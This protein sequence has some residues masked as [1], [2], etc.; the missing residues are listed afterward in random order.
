MYQDLIAQITDQ[1]IKNYVLM[2]PQNVMFVP[3]P[4]DKSFLSIQRSK[5]ELDIFPTLNDLLSFNENKK[6]TIFTVP[7]KPNITL[8]V[9][10][11]F[12]NIKK[13][14]VIYDIYIKIQ[15]GWLIVSSVKSIMFK[16]T[17]KIN[18]NEKSGN[19]KTYSRL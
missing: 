17:V 13:Q 4:S 18:Q 1:Q 7:I 8:I 15:T 9:S 3:V 14:R 16:N 12:C 5:S 19:F 2:A 10:Y 6:C 11:Y